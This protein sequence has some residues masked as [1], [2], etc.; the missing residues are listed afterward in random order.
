MR[1][2][3]LILLFLSLSAPA[4]AAHPVVFSASAS[5]AVVRMSGRVTYTVVCEWPAGWTVTPPP[6]R[7]GDELDSFLVLKRSD[8]VLEQIEDGRQ[9]M[10]VVYELVVDQP[11]DVEIPPLTIKLRGP[12]GREDTGTVPAV[13]LRV[14]GPVGKITDFARRGLGR[15]AGLENVP[16]AAMLKLKDQERIAREWRKLAVSLAVGLLGAAVL[17]LLVL[18]LVR[19]FRK[20]RRQIKDIPREAPEV[21]ARRRLNSEE[22][23][24]LL[25][26]REPKPYYTELTDIVREYLEG[27]FAIPAR[28]QTT[29]EILQAS[30]SCDLQGGRPFLREL[31]RVADWVKFAGAAAPFERWAADRDRTRQ[32]VETTTPTAEPA[33]APNPSTGDAARPA[34][35]GRS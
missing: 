7:A 3:T 13:A 17:S 6:L 11:F 28:E 15:M 16:D 22:L 1:K 2:W 25:E 31:F 8:P 33:V 5:P 23:Q 30:E 35:G 9:R 19:R 20:R 14:I 12:G 34:T 10:T 29:T 26:K 21:I 32:F 18:Y 4:L 24:K 27:R